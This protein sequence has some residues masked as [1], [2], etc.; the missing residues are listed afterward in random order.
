MS[1]LVTNE[2][3]EHIEEESNEVSWVDNVELLYVLLVSVNRREF[4][5][6]QIIQ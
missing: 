5:V 6:G 1:K 4:V 2:R 3:F